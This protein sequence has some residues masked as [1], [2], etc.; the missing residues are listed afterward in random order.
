MIREFRLSSPQTKRGVS[1]DESGA[2]VGAVPLLNRRGKAG[3]ARW[4]PRDCARLSKEIGEHFRLPIDISSK[5]GGLKAIS[6]ALNDGDIARAQIATVLLGI[7]DPPFLAKGTGDRSEMI[8]F[9]QEL[10]R[11]GLIKADWDPDAHPRWPAGAP[12]SQ[13]GQFA[14]KADGEAAPPSHGPNPAR[15]ASSAAAVA[16][17]Q[18][19]SGGA[20]A[21]PY[22]APL[23]E[24]APLEEAPLEEAPVEPLVPRIDIV[25]PA[26]VPR[27]LYKPPAS[28]PYPKR[29]KCEKEWADAASY[30]AKLV[31]E[32]KLG[33][34]GYR[35]VGGRN[36]DQ[37][38]RGQVSADCGGNPTAFEIFS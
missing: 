25:P 10:D 27:E 17:I 2:F 22:W 29:R 33:A 30:C 19:Q 11:S 23:I 8:R 6:K 24:Q 32:R 31:K 13:G 26:V 34:S 7:P 12:D 14:P 35:G 28:N 20:L 16:R 21:V 15:P 1:C 4:E 9:I 5:M 18:V 3:R 36:W 37:C 38:L